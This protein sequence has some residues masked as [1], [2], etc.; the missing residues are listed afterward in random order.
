[1]PKTWE[2]T[3]TVTL[4]T[5]SNVEEDFISR[6]FNRELGVGTKIS[7]FTVRSISPIT[8]VAEI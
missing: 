5:D 4:N 7:N 6:V 3:V 1:M 8:V 2:G